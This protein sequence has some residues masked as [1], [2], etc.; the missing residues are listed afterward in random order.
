[1]PKRGRSR[2]GN[3]P[4][5]WSLV[6]D[7]LRRGGRPGVIAA[8]SFVVPV[9]TIALLLPN[10]YRAT[11]TVLIERQQIPDE[12]VRSTVTSALETRLHSITQEILSRPQLQALKE[13]FGLDADLA[14]ATPNEQA[15]AQLRDRV[16]V[17]IEPSKISRDRGNGAA[18]AF[19]VSY[20]GR[21]PERVALVAN[22]LAAAYVE[23]NLNMRR[24]EAAGTADFLRA[25]LDTTKRTLEQQEREVSAFKGQHAGELP[26]QLEANLRTLEQLN[27]QLRLNSENQV[28]ASEQR[29]ALM[30]QLNEAEGMATAGGPDAAGNRL[31]QL[32]QSLAV[33]QAR[34]SER[35]PDVV[36]V[37]AEIASLEAELS[38]APPESEQPETK[39][40][41]ANPVNFQLKQALDAANVELKR[42]KAEEENLRR[43]LATYQ[44]RVEL[45][46]KREQESQALLRDYETTKELYRSLV[47]RERESQLA[48]DMEQGKKGE[49]FRIIEPALPA[50][51]PAAPRRKVMIAFALA[52]SFVLGAAVV[53]ARELLDRSF[54]VAE[55]VQAM[56]R[57]P[58]LVSI[59][60]VLTVGDRRSQ[61]KRDA[62]AAMLV[63]ASLALSIALSYVIAK[64]NWTLSALLLRLVS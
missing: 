37:K 9:S 45:A 15:I 53:V 49:Q 36:R 57:I 13:R 38:K 39:V 40:V 2:T 59:P 42:L 23:Q 14:P 34:Y 50:L 29:A 35:Y 19:T 11:T 24:Q 16:R 64:D 55:D 56:A 12:L 1:M 6:G 62:R 52:C 26:Q 17:Q 18:V 5:L 33:L 60:S 30:R 48:E 7:T 4:D 58:V 46:P 21:D 43:S 10:V 8:L 25:Q 63:L 61:R 51:A 47:V 20:A 41:S 28:R 31:T 22:A 54:H 44:Q 32:K 3:G 27:A